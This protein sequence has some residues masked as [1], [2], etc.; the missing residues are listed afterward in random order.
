MTSEQ[1]ENENYAKQADSEKYMKP[2]GDFV[3]IDTLVKTYP[4]YNH[5]DVFNLT[6]SEVYSMT[7]LNRQQAYISSRAN[8]IRQVILKAKNK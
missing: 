3:T 4:A 5:D 8:E 1:Q 6:V 2:H 7:L